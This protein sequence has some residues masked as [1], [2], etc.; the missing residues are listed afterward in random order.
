MRPTLSLLALLPAVA[1]AQNAGDVAGLVQSLTQLG[2]TQLVQV[3]AQLNTTSFGQSLLRNLTS[4]DPYLIFAP[5]N[6]AWSSAP[7]NL[8]D[9]PAVLTSL[10][11]YHIVPGN[12]SNA[13]STYPNVTLG[14]TLLTDPSFVALEGGRPQVVAWATRGD[15]RTHVLNQRNDSTVVSTGSWNNLTL[16]VVDHVLNIPENL[17]STIPT[18]NDSLQDFES[19]LRS[20][21]LSFYNSTTNQTGDTTFFEAFNQGY[22]GFT[23][24]APNND[25]VEG[26]NSTIN[27]FRSTNRTAFNAALFNTFINGT[28]LYSPLLAGNQSYVTANGETLTFSSNSTG[29]YV[30]SQNTTAR[31]VQPDVLLPNGVVHIIDRFLI[32][33]ETDEGAK[34]SALQSATSAATASQASQTAPIGHSIT[35]SLGNANPTGSNSPSGGSSGAL[36]T[37]SNLLGVGAAFVATLFGGFVTVF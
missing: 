17:Q 27:N 33:T 14:Q 26:A 20:G 22:H 32:N 10:F 1:Y 4:G 11:G 15:N 36:M 19:V 29:Q 2:L 18:N 23:L 31:I 30:T 16:W 13:T 9:N 25:A 3:A 34:S 5:N 7:S 12:F 8:T 37:T 35:Q 6:A 28:T 21:Q 24:F